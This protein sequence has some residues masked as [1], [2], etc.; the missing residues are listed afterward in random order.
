MGHKD[1]L[2]PPALFGIQG[3]GNMSGS[4]PATCGWRPYVFSV[5]QLFRDTYC[6]VLALIPDAMWE[7]LSV[8]LC[9]K[10]R[11]MCE[12]PTLTDDLDK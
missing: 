9:T 3:T 10:L 8:A 2:W 4:K 11:R 1:I 7:F 5:E 6:T 12:V